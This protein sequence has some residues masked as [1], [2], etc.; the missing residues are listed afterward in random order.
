MKIIGLLISIAIVAGNTELL[1][2][3][4]GPIVRSTFNLLHTTNAKVIISSAA[5]IV[6]FMVL[7]KIWNLI[8]QIQQRKERQKAISTLTPSA[9]R[10]DYII[11]R[12]D[13]RRGN[14]K[15]SR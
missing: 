1:S 13:Y 7:K 8:A 3:V 4:F 15:E 6:L 9:N 10:D 12:D 14:P 5:V 2:K 11:E